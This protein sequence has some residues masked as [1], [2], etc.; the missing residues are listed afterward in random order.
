T[1]QKSPPLKINTLLLHFHTQFSARWKHLKWKPWI[2]KPATILLKAM[3]KILSLIPVVR[4][5][6]IAPRPCWTTCSVA[7]VRFSISKIIIITPW[8]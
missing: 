5:S 7:S 3:N 8:I 4:A 1:H 2:P 6:T